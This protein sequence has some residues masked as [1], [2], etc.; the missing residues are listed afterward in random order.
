L[1]STTTTHQTNDKSPTAG[2]N[3]AGNQ[4]SF[5]YKILDGQ[6]IAYFFFNFGDGKQRNIDGTPDTD[7]PGERL[8]LTAA[9][10]R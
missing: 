7:T 4:V 1:V 2:D 5:G 10:I 8:P 6:Q 9:L 3:P